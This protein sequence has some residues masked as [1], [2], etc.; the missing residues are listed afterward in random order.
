MNVGIIDIDEQ[1]EVIRFLKEAFSTC[2]KR[3]SFPLKGTSYQLKPTGPECDYQFEVVNF[4]QPLDVLFMH[5][6]TMKGPGGVFMDELWMEQLLKAIPFTNSAKIYFYS[7][8]IEEFNDH[9]QW[10]TR[11]KGGPVWPSH[12]EVH[13]LDVFDLLYPEDQD[14]DE[15]LE[16][17]LF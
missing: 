7:G 2:S 4:K 8:D 9:V 12:L 17:Q 14:M 10:M 13:C 1:D 11:R 5:T 3:K 16:S 6:K 15:W